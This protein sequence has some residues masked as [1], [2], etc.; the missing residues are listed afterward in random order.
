MGCGNGGASPSSCG[1][2]SMVRSG[3]S[4]ASGIS[5]GGGGGAM[6]WKYC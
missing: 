4:G 2:M 3:G 1:G 6:A 5:G